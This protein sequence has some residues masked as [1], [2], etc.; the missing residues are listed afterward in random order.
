MPQLLT[1]GETMVCFTP[2]SIGPLRYV[3][4]YT[5]RIAGAE[6]N[7]A[8]G[9]QKL[10]CSSGWIGKLG[11]DELGRYILNNIR[12]EGVDCTHVKIDSQHRTGLMLKQRSSRETSVFYYRENSAASFLSP[13]DLDES[14]F[15]GAEILHLTGITPVLSS[16]CLQTVNESIEIAKEKRMLISFD[17]NVRKKLWKTTDYSSVIRELTLQADIVLMGLDEAE[18]LFHTREI[19]HLFDIILENNP[20]ALIAV[21]DGANGSVV[22]NSAIRKHIEPYPC[23]RLETIGAG[24]AFNAGFLAG[25]LQG[26]DIDICGKMGNIAGALA[27]ETPGDIEGQPTAEQMEAALH[28]LNTVY[29]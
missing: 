10:G 5:A 3:T 12:S 24:D 9:V 27:T 17:P 22:G 18:I 4:N 28:H 2:D 15:N 14:Y 7:V 20:H 16:S 19:N 11:D 8:I 25:V 1:L 29:R 6:S 13:D 26:R 21:K 23:Q